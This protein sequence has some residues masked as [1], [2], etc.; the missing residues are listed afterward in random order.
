MDRFLTHEGQ[1]PIWLGDIDFMT[2]AFRDTVAELARG[3]G[4]G[5]SSFILYGLEFDSERVGHE[6]WTFSWKAGVVVIDEELYPVEA[7]EFDSP[8]NIE[9]IGFKI[10]KSF[11][12]KG[13]RTMKNGEEKECYELRKAVITIGGTD[14]YIRGIKRFKNLIREQCPSPYEKSLGHEI[15]RTDNYRIGV[16]LLD[17]AGKFYMYYELV[18]LSSSRPPK[19][20]DLSATISFNFE[21]DKTAFSISS[22]MRNKTVAFP[23]YL[24]KEEANG[25]KKAL[26]PTCIATF[27]IE[28][29]KTLGVDISSSQDLQGQAKYNGSGLIR[30]SR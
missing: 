12:S 11:D 25:E 8:V 30:L 26:A 13:R 9:F 4:F 6:M 21:D 14:L 17:I 15:V 27:S 18:C 3:M 19:G 2:S 28:G 10:V 29:E 7:G 20:P 1:Q 22:D 16:K 23:V 24:V 5:S